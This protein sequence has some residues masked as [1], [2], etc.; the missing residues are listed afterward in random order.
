MP[1]HETG[2]AVRVSNR[3]FDTFTVKSVLK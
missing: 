2:S 3:V 1:L